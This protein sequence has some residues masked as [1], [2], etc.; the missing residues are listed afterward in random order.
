MPIL[1][2]STYVHGYGKSGVVAV[3]TALSLNS[4]NNTQDVFIVKYNTLGKALWS[5]RVG[6]AGADIGYGIT[7]DSAGNVYVTGQSSFGINMASFNSDG[8]AFTTTLANS[9]GNDTFV[10]KYNTS[11]F[12]QWVAR[13]AS[14]GTDIGFAITTDSGGNVYVTGQGGS[15]TVTAFSSNGTAFATTLSN[16]G[17]GDAFIVKYN[18]SGI[19]Q[20]VARVATVLAADIG[21]GI[22]TDSSGNVYVTGQAGSGTVTA[23]NSDGSAFATTLVS[24]GG[25][26]TF[27]VKY[28]TSG[29]VQW[30]ARVA[31]TGQDL[32]YGIATD[33]GGNVYVTG[34]GGQ[35][36]VT[37]FNFNGT[38]FVTTLSNSGGT[39]AFV[40]K[41]D[42]TGL[43]QWV[44]KI[45]STG[46]DI[47]FAI[48]TDSGGNVYVTG[49]GGSATVT[50]FNS[51][52]TSFATTLPN[53]G[54]GDAFI[55]K[56]NT[57]GVVQWVARIASI[58][59]DIAYGIATDSSGNVYITG[60]GGNIRILSAFNSNGTAF[61]T[62][63]ANSGSTDTFIVKYNTSGFVQWVTRIASNAF[64]NG[65]AITVDSSSNVYL[66]G[67]FLGMQFSI[68]GQG[69]SL[70]ATRASNGGSDVFIVKYTTTGSPQWVAVI[71]VFSADIGYGI[72]T[73]SGGNV[74]VTGQGGA[75]GP[76]TAFNSDG[77]SFATTLPNSG[78]ND[79]FV[80][81]YNTSG[82]VQWVAKIASTGADIGRGI[83]TDSA[84]NVYVTGQGGADVV[85]TAF[86]SNGT[87]FATT[88]SNSGN[89][90]AFLVKYN[91]NGFVQWVAR[92][93]SG[94][95]DIGYG[96]DTDSDGNVYITGQGGSNAEITAFNSNGTAF[97]TTL[98]GS[99]SND[100]FIVKYNT[101]GFVQWVARLGSTGADIGFAIT[102]DSAGNVYVTGQ[103][104]AGAVVT[105]FNSNGTSFTTTLPNSGGT[106]AFIVKYNTSGVVQWV[107]RIASTAG[108]IGYGIATDSL[109]NVYVVGVTG[110]AVATAFNSDGTSFGTPIEN[111]GSGEAFIVKY[112]T[113][114]FVQWV[115][116]I[117][118][119]TNDYGWS[120]ATDSLGNVYVTSSGGSDDLNTTI[121]NSD[122]QVFTT[123]H[124]PCSVVKYDT[125]GF[126]QWVQVVRGPSGSPETRSVATDSVGNVFITGGISNQLFVYNVDSTP[127][128]IMSALGSSD[129]FI[130]KYS[131]STFPLWAAKIDSGGI[132]GVDEGTSIATD[133][134]GNVYVTGQGG[135]DTVTA[136]NSDGTAFATT[137]SNSGSGDAFLVKYNTSGLVQWV[138]KIASFNSDVGRGV[139]ADSAGNVYITGQGGSG[140][141]LN[142]FNSD[143]SAFATIIDNSGSNDAFLVKYNTS[144]FV[145][146]VARVASI[147]GDQGYDIAADSGDNVYVIGAGG[148]GAAI[149]AFNSNGTSFATTLANSGGN[150]AFLVK[151]N[152]SGFVQ[153]VAR[154]ASTG[155][156]IG[157]GIATDSSGNVYVTGQ[158]GSGAIVTA[159]NSDG[160]S[161]AT[162]LANSGG[163]DTFVVKYNTSG[164]VQWV[165][166]IASTSDDI[167][168]AIA[169]D[170]AGN[171]YVTGL[172]GSAPVTAFSS[173]G[174]A[175][176]TTLPNLANGD[177]FIVKY[178]TS[179]IVQWVARVASSGTDIGFAITTDS[180]GNVYLTGSGGNSQIVTAR[181][182]DGSIFGSAATPV[183][184]LTSSTFVV[185]YNSSGFVQWISSMD[186]GNSDGGRGIAL[187]TSSNI[188]VTGS[189]GGG[190]LIPY[191]A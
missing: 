108:E 149:T 74:Y 49:Q 153:W 156:D 169:A 62:T 71:A 172:G 160:T 124:G 80:V 148:G 43:V 92:V 35:A 59:S 31:S 154:V 55:V 191:S 23:F 139:I 40:V 104:G 143:G 144:G 27:I 162:T 138:A 30:L 46:A 11:G 69:L 106:D 96:I 22:A 60:Q 86:N 102:T 94:G 141:V 103:G 70:F 173:N 151:Y 47:G 14:T 98:G 179:G 65:R 174:T 176:A 113:S 8:T 189:F 21:Y 13:V 93:A 112:N 121:F 181:N 140:Q 61:G 97:A 50:A 95:A 1:V 145:Q 187:D 75:S 29:L 5:A 101:S 84:G 72:A 42:T 83:A 58:G 67:Q 33:S 100:T 164:F 68:Y 25:T 32:G 57:S 161:F 190:R 37:A 78:S 91:T 130:V 125:N 171:V 48:T 168:F 111:A 88:L 158:G 152:T 133:S 136:F 115:A 155:A 51:N 109:S 39:D 120:I 81:K 24:S 7:T 135:T 122:T 178:N 36:T 28:N 150:D 110:N 159:F 2:S 137:L 9:G 12:V 107:T 183:L 73:D 19:V 166:R 79:T 63:I 85:V 77:T 38:S 105:A 119:T 16:S 175:F 127:Y 66:T 123:T 129:V 186:G 87:A 44:A 18:T 99:G 56:Y 45:A 82:F 10:V 90:D 132:G 188:Y 177:A 146:W 131:S 89:N 182:S 163:N 15:A 53:S 3:E 142:A 114:G 6:S 147:F 4:T 20:W 116:R 185:K 167:G 64:D 126:A 118:T 134:G 52:G 128:K 170:S 184:G 165:A 41:Y 117:S 180:G 157:Y 34:Q 54:G 76:I 26:D 17:S